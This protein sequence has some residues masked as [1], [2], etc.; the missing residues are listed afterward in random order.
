MTMSL[1]YNFDTFLPTF[2]SPSTFK[3]NIY[4]YN[5]LNINHNLILIYLLQRALSTFI[6]LAVDSGK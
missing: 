2:L 3:E 6:V 1:P 5:Y 4:L